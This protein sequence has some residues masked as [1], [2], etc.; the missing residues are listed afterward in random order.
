MLMTTRKEAGMKCLWKGEI[1]YQLTMTKES[2]KI[3]VKENEK[4]EGRIQNGLTVVNLSP[5]K[6]EHS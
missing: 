3:Q 1:T 2:F 5:D 4:K 6:N